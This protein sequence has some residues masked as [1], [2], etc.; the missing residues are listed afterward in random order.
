MDFFRN[1]IIIEKKDNISITN[2]IVS[3]DKATLD[4]IKNSVEKFNMAHGSHNQHSSSKE[5]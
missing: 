3:T 5:Y 1:E 2:G 4:S